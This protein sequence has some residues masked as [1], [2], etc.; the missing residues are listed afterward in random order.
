MKHFSDLRARLTMG[1]W[2]ARCGVQLTAM[3]IALLPQLGGVVVGITQ[4]LAHL[5][6]QL[7]HQQ[8]RHLIVATIGHGQLSGQ[9][10]PDPSRAITARCN[11]QSYHQ[12]CQPDW[13]QPASV[14]SELGG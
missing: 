1:V 3:S 12:P 6:R 14:S 7:C 8:R 11:F 13:F 5:S 2:A 10:T 4:H 9:W